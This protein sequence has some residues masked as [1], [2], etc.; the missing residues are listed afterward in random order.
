ME[1]DRQE[2][3]G[4]GSE[5]AFRPQLRYRRDLERPTPNDYYITIYIACNV[6]PWSK[7]LEVSTVEIERQRN[8]LRR[9]RMLGQRQ[10]QQ[11]GAV[12]R[13][14]QNAIDAISASITQL[15]GKYI[16]GKTWT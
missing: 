5:Q 8:R 9:H 14:T 13:Q 15:R 6:C 2:C 1:I 12:Q 7:D 10:I 4:C 16:Q 3:P 11:F